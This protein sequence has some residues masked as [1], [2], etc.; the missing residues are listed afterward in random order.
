MASRPDS[1]VRFASWAAWVRG[2]LRPAPLSRKAV[3]KLSIFGI[4]L[5]SDAKDEVAG[6]PPD[7]EDAR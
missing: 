7:R 5:Q 3:E 1:P 6:F 4:I 2:K